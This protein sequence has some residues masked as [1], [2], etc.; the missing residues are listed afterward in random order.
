MSN[1]RSR[2][3]PASRIAATVF[4]A[5]ILAAS[6]AACSSSSSPEASPTPGA[7][8]DRSE[9]V[10]SVS[11]ITPN[12]DPSTVTNLFLASALG[13]FDDANVDVEIVN[14][15]GAA[16]AS[17][18]VS[19]EADLLLSSSTIGFP[20]AKQGQP[21]SLIFSDVGGGLGAGLSVASDSKYKDLEDLAGKKVGTIGTTGGTYGFANLLSKTVVDD[22]GAPFEIVAFNDAATMN[23]ALVSGQVDAVSAST[24]TVAA[25]VADGSVRTIIDTS[26]PEQRQEYIGS[27]YTIDTGYAGLR[28]NLEGKRES[29]VRLLEALTRADDY[30]TSHSAEEISEMLSQ[31]ELFSALTVDQINQS[32]TAREPFY[33]P[34]R[35]K[36][37]EDAWEETL[38]WFTRWNIPSLGDVAADPTFTYDEVVDMSYLTEAQERV[39]VEG[40]SSN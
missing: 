39:A 7:T 24:G 8:V 19:G 31:D 12:A 28:D 6:L 13:Y 32:V 35:G 20:L 33:T 5:G 34:D 27:D 37:S 21:I 11:V 36:I 1:H 15:A 26:D 14:G 4:T 40:E 3:T 9:T 22:G 29:V 16:G 23:N 17:L 18:L 38:D 30:R 25:L 10:D 2:F